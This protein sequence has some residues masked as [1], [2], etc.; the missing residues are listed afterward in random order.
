MSLYTSPN[1]SAN[2]F[3]NFLDKL[4]LTMESITQ[5]NLFLTVAIGDFNVRPSK[6]W[7]DDK[8]TREGLKIEN[9]LLSQFSL[10]QVFNK[11]THISRNFKFCINLLLTN[12][13][14]LITDSEVHPSLY[15]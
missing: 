11:P 2:E 14:N 12:Q 1:Q 15:S 7:T 5:G 4:N 13:Q 10:S 8:T 9:N 6:W 3:E